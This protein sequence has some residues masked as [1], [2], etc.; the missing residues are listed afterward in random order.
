MALS[1]VVDMIIK[2]YA[3][4]SLPNLDVD[5]SIPQ[6]LQ[7]ELRDLEAAMNSM[8]DAS[9]QVADNPPI[10]P[11]KGMVRY[12]VTPW[13]PLSNN[14][15]GLVVYTG[16]AWAN[17]SP[18]TGGNTFTASDESKLDGIEASA[19]ADQTAAQIKTLLAGVTY[20]Q[21]S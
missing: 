9:V 3:R 1:D 17:V 8:A 14:F 4:R 5:V 10:S 11:R 20:A 19:T 7:T 13:N 6:Y 21:L 12:A 18:A 15:S 16:V 2:R